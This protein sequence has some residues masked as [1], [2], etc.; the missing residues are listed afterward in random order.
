MSGQVAA[1]SPGPN[2]GGHTAGI[3]SVKFIDSTHAASAGHDRSIRIWRIED[4]GSKL[5][6]TVNFIP[7]LELCG[8]KW[9]INAIDIH[10]SSSRLLSGSDD[11][12]LGVWSTQKSGA[13]AA[14]EVLLPQT[15]RLSKKR[16]KVSSS[17][18]PQKGCLSQLKGHTGSVSDT[19]FA[20]NDHTVAYS[21]SQDHTL[22][23]WDIPTGSLVDTRTTMNPLC[24]IEAIPD[25][26]LVAVGNSARFITLVDPRASATTTSV[27]TLRG[28]TNQVVT[29]S[30]DPGNKHGLLS[31]S[32]DG[33]C[34]IWDLRS[35]K[36][37]ADGT[38]SESIYT[39]PR[40][41][42]KIGEKRVAGE[43]VKVFSSV[44]DKEVGIVSGS[45]DKK[46]QIDRGT[47]TIPT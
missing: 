15:S 27:M 34:R 46:V 24:S 31:G 29:L 4:D 10:N 35:T 22:R 32:H 13:P 36:N 23:T 6:T 41:W 25:L 20:P 18:V 47:S 1:I 43:G 44:W 40:R 30:R 37:S 42:L 7:E 11:W 28:H 2:E 17:Q 33:T 38:V 45:E 26:N 16:R 39:L 12:T 3:K 21:A 14:P 8:H 19:I 5:E 9:G